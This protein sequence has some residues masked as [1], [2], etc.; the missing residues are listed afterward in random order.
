MNTVNS[1]RDQLPDKKIIP[2]NTLIRFQTQKSSIYRRVAN[3]L[4]IEKK[5]INFDTYFYLALRNKKKI[6]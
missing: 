4:R 6:Y 3:F 5:S 1:D 2:T